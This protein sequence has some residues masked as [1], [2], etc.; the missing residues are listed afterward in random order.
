MRDESKENGSDVVSGCELTPSRRRQLSWNGWLKA[1]L[2]AGAAAALASPS[3]AFQNEAVPGEARRAVLVDGQQLDLQIVEQTGQGDWLFLRDGQRMTVRRGD[4]VKWGDFHDRSQRMWVLLCD[5]SLLVADLLSIN[6]QDV[7]LA[8]RLWSETRI[9][10]Q[11]VRAFVFRPVVDTLERDQL[12]FRAVSE[13][14][15]EDHL[16]LENGDELRG[17]LP[18][19][20]KPEPGAFH[21]EKIRWLVPGTEQS[22]EMP[23][24]RVSAI[25]L[26]TRQPAPDHSEQATWVG[27]SDGSRVLA[28]EIARTERSLQFVL[29]SGVSLATDNHATPAGEPFDAVT[30]LQPLSASVTYLSDLDPLGYKHIAFLSMPWPYG[31]DRTAAGGQLRYQGQ[32]CSK[33]VGMHSSSRLA[34]SLAGQYHWFQAELALDE[35]AGHEG[36]VVYRV[37]LQ[38]RSGQWNQAHESAVVRGSEELVSVRVDVQGAAALALIVDFADRADQWDHANWLNARLIR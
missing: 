30:M 4:L 23:L 11:A 21:P 18:A 15:Q 29:L 20:V 35:R 14:R 1:I 2:F 16:L 33:G 36:S 3:L 31:D 17:A 13:H 28:R 8:G 27:L 7:V 5:G 24:E 34:Y 19:E 26:A 37:Y 22:V 10:R 12:Y 6:S 25:L 9:P 32:V 38:D